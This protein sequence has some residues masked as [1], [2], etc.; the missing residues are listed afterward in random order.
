[1]PELP[2]DAPTE[3]ELASLPRPLPEEP[4][5]VTLPPRRSLGRLTV[6]NSFWEARDV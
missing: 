6:P 5:T 4:G 2:G 3:G 1:M